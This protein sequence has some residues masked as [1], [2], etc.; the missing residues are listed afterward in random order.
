MKEADK[1]TYTSSWKQV[2]AEFIS[3]MNSKLLR[4][5]SGYLKETAESKQMLAR[6]RRG[7]AKAPAEDPHLWDL[8]ELP[9]E[10]IRTQ[11]TTRYE[12]GAHLALCLYA[13]HQQSRDGGVHKAGRS[14]ARAIG[15]AV[16]RQDENTAKTIRK[17]FMAIA[18]AQSFSAVAYHLRSLITYVRGVYIPVND[19]D[20]AV[21]NT[22]NPSSESIDDQ[23]KE[24][25]S[26][27]YAQLAWDLA[28]LQHTHG[29]KIVQQRWA[30]DYGRAH[31][32]SNSQKTKKSSQELRR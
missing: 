18:T 16:I 12:W 19:K 30:R 27:D 14:F 10:C 32:Y 29:A 20:D 24:P 9:E 4:L 28:Q 3:T 25:V 23:K 5:Q 15:E 2:E 11:Y 6:L 1:M 7:I 17:R 31:L 26:F 13:I 8:V 21:D 22:D